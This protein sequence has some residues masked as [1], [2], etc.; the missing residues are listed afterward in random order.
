MFEGALSE[1]ATKLVGLATLF[2]LSYVII[3][4]SIHRGLKTA[5]PDLSMRHGLVSLLS[6][7]A[8]GAAAFLMLV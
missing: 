3:S 1:L 6:V 8:F 4:L 2:F 7:V 5:I